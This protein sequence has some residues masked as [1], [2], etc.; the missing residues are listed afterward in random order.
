[1]RWMKEG[2]FLRVEYCGFDHLQDLH[3]ATILVICMHVL[4]ISPDL[5]M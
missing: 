2:A 1:M 3:G 5:R 4:W